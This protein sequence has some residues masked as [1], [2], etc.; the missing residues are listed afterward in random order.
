MID[1]GYRK[2][3]AAMESDS[4]PAGMQPGKTRI[5]GIVKAARPDYK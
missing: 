2:Y 5:Y 4:M 3:P 1:V